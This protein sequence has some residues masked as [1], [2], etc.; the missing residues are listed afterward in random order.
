[1][2]ATVVAQGYFHPEKG[3]D[4]P[5]DVRC[6]DKYAWL[7]VGEFLCEYTKLRNTNAAAR[8]IADEDLETQ[9]C[10]CASFAGK[11]VIIGN[12]AESANPVRTYTLPYRFSICAYQVTNRLYSLFA[13]AH[14]VQTEEYR[15]YSPYPRGPAVFLSWH[16]SLMFS[17]WAHGYLPNE[18]IWEYASRAEKVYE[19]GQTAIWPWGDSQDESGS[20][21]WLDTNSSVMECAISLSGE[22]QDH[23]HTVGIKTPNGFGL[24]DT[25]GNVWE[26]CLNRYDLDFF[27]VRRGGSFR[28]GTFYAR[29]SSRD[30]GVRSDSDDNS[31]CRV[32]R[33]CQP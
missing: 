22:I 17:I 3:S 8:Q 32:V 14:T 2:W 7:V 29:C 24:H 26:W 21:A 4:L 1:M 27:R 25:I 9:M 20:S 33:P 11:G 31:G 30:C 15:I 18:W 5:V 13:A 12:R 6:Q 10:D 23:A 19:S 28:S 16:D